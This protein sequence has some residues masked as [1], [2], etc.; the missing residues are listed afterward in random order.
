MAEFDFK[1]FNSNLQKKLN[2]LFTL[3]APTSQDP[4]D[5][6][7]HKYYVAKT[8]EKLFKKVAEDVLNK[9]LPPLM[10]PR[11]KK[12][13]ADLISEAKKSNSKTDG[14]ILVAQDYTFELECKKPAR[15]FSKDKL[16]V[17]LSK[18]GWPLDQID[19]LIEEC[20]EDGEP[21]KTYMVKAIHG[22]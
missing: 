12:A 15:R 1:K 4:S 14:V 17:A 13:L 21:A 7:L 3:D 10:S 18:R 8:G 2:A 5:A 6:L 20:E 19:V 9:E 11:A 22:G 16:K